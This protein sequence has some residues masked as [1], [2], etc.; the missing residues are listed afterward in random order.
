MIIHLMYMCFTALKSVIVCWLIIIG[1]LLWKDTEHTSSDKT[2]ILLLIKI[3]LGWEQDLIFF[4]SFLRK[5]VEV[6]FYGDDG[7]CKTAFLDTKQKGPK[8]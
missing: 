4:F 5:Y 6:N 3:T 1:Y 8:N 2:K 7:T